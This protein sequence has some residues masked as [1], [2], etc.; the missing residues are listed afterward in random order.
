MP[1]R[2]PAAVRLSLLALLLLVPVCV[3]AGTPTDFEK[4]APFSGMTLSGQ[5]VTLETIRLGKPF[6]VLTFFGVSCIPCQKKMGQLNELWR[7]DRFRE[8][9]ALYA[10]NADGLSAEK[11]VEE[12]ARR[13]I[14]IDFPVI[15][16][17]NQAITNLYVDGIV[18][19]TVVIDNQ[20]RVVISLVG[21]RPEGARKMADHILAEQEA[22]LK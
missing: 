11:L 18:P 2:L 12:M 19:L 14:K 4:A 1:R 8:K 16:D 17:D 20:D 6:A 5:K 22:R 9:T 15:A 13:N 3:R 21:A 7:D 10:V